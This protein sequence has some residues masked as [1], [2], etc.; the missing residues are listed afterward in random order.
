MSKKKLFFTGRSSF[1]R[2]P[3]EKKTRPPETFTFAPSATL[4]GR[5]KKE[6]GNR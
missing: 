1:H 6:K 4:H 5:R 2:L 3:E